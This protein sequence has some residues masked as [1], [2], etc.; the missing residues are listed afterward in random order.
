M[1]K[2]KSFFFHCHLSSFF[3]T[4]IVALPK[5]SLSLSLRSFLCVLPTQTDA[6]GAEVS[7]NEREKERRE[8]K[9]GGG[10]GS[11]RGH[12]LGPISVENETERAGEEQ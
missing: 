5:D 2:R 4:K 12:G 10:G 9:G 1:R 8:E 7:R 6:E 11:V 3:R